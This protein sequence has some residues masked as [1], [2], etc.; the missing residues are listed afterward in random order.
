[1]PSRSPLFGV[2]DLDNDTVDVVVELFAAL[3][4]PG[5]ALGDLAEASVT[6]GVGVYPE[7]E[8]TE[9]VQAF[10]VARRDRTF[11]PSHLVD[12]DGEWTLGGDGG[13]ELA[14]GAG[15]GVARVREKGFA[16]LGPLRVHALETALRHIDL[17][18]HF[19]GRGR[20]TGEGEGDGADG[21]EVGGDVLAAT[22]VAAGSAL[23]EGSPLVGQGDGEA[24][25]LRLGGEGEVV[26]AGAFG[27][28][29]VPVGKV[30]VGGGVGEAEKGAAVLDRGEGL[31]GGGAHAQRGGVGGDELGIGGFEGAELVHELVVLAVADLGCVEHV[32]AV[33][34]VVD[35][36]A[37]LL[38]AEPGLVLIRG[39]H[40]PSILARPEP[41]LDRPHNP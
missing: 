2:V 14:H 9:P 15:G 29:A 21:A 22:A 38:A 32:V 3:A 24:V 8:V 41:S 40:P 28:A 10:E 30:I 20:I 12:V 7:A 23:D 16:A 18:A 19:E 1:M 27:G 6:P 25:D 31:E 4:P 17:A 13:V 37:Q 34:V 35:E 26:A 5:H 36:R 39:R 33:V 11:A